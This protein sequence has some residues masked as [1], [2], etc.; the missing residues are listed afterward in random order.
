MRRTAWASVV[1]AVSLIGAACS[2]DD[3]DSVAG[4]T[5]SAATPTSGAPGDSTPDSTDVGSTEPAATSAPDDAARGGVLVVAQS[6]DPTS[7]NPYRFGSTN[8]RSIITNMFEP[9]IEFD[10]QTYD[11][12]GALADDWSTSD[13]G[14]VWTFNL[15][16]GVTFHDGSTLDAADVVASIERAKEPEASRTSTLLSRVDEVVPV[17]DLT[18]EVHL[19]EPDR[20]LALTLID[21]YITPEDGSIDQGVTPVG[22]GP[23]K[24]V[25]AEANQQ[26]VLERNPDYWQDG[27]PLLDGVE[28]RTVPD[29]TVQSLQI[30]TGDVDMLATTPLGE[31]GSLQAAGVQIIG[32]AEGFNSGFYHFHTNT[33]RD[34][35]SNELV[36]RAASSA[37]DREAISRS[38][39]GFMQVLSN[40]ME[41][42]PDFLNADAPSYDERDLDGAKALMA[43]A[44]FAD[45]VDGGELIVC[46][47][48][49]QYSTLA[50][51][52]QLQ[53]AEI[54]IDITISLLD[55][56][57]YVARTLGDDAGNFDLAMCGMVPKPNEYDLLNHPYAKLFTNA[58]GWIDQKPEFYELIESARSMVDDDEYATAI[59]DLQM[60]AMEGQPEIIIGGMI[61][62]VAAVPGIDGFVAHTQGHLYLENVSKQD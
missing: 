20:I 38:L 30:K 56:G 17:D 62:P 36:R 35:W 45:G 5:T 60:M 29:P 54:G 33:R 16:E 49:F 46:D 23:F 26:V 58:L 61:T 53:L 28:F 48:G 31:I 57:T 4:D 10:L 13:D 55:V 59:A 32:P 21:V 1:I 6:A 43:E 52:V 18:V 22:T 7:L 39:F 15:H 14:L 8:D 9:I 3:D 25:S 44:G 50:Q 27:L 24:F 42:E 47:L 51:L 2:G 11:I 41:V 40:P 12:V 19:T 34:P 37:L